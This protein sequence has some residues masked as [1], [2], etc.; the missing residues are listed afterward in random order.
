[1]TSYPYQQDLQ[2]ILH[3]MKQAQ[4]KHGPASAELRRD[5]LLRS[6]LLLRENQ[7]AIISAISADFGHRSEYQTMAADLVTTMNML[8]H[9]ADN[10]EEWMRPEQAEV[11]VAGMQAWIEPQP[12]GVVGIISPWNFAINLAFG[13]LAGVFA[14]GNTA[15][16]KPSELTPATSELLAEI[17][18]RYFGQT[19]LTVVLGDASVGQAFSALPFDHLVFTGST[20]VGKQV[21]RAAA[22]NLV[23]VTL[24]LGGKS[25]VVMDNDASP[26]MTAER[27]MTIKTFNAGQICISPDYLLLPEAAEAAFVE[28][29][30][31][32]VH[33]TLPSIQDNTDY[34]AII[35]D[36]HYQR[37]INLLKDAASKGA[38]IISLAPEGEVDFDAS[39]RKIAPHLV[40][41]VTEEM[42]IMQEEIFGPLLPIKTYSGKLDDVIAMI[43]A[44]PRPLAAYYFGNT[45]E[46]QQKMIRSTTSGALVINDV[47]THASLD[48]LPFGGVGAS[49]MGAYHGIH[50]FRRFSHA[51]PVVIQNEE[52]TTNLRLRAP[53]QANLD[54]L[55]A[56]FTH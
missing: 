48:S 56:A 44:G 6:I 14:A 16:L 24:E 55:K 52:G 23:P 46:G 51:K 9:S 3:M 37:L 21:M 10:L 40:L 43:N 12:L 49:G 11:P 18:P 54:A 17:V 36:R 19:E 39:S 38:K 13:P 32:F 1:M 29:A 22:E 4:L 31:A 15:M 50:G 33:R 35:N 5:R 2:R 25:P 28:A 34:T 27:T 7:Q 45:E 41:D 30:S 47:M 26:V 53:Y 20:A 8:Q 42:A